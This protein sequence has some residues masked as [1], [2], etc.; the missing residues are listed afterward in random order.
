MVG[1]SYDSE[2]ILKRFAAKRGITFPL[3]SDE[4]SKTIEAYGIRNREQAGQRWDGIPHPGTFLIDRKGI[5]RAKIF[6][7]NYRERH[8]SADLL[9]AA[10][11]LP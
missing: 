10:K 8:H 3:L 9:D 1:V 2:A 11:K 7:E 4:G 5:I 6:Y